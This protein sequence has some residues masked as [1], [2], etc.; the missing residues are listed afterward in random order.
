[1]DGS[2]R[3]GHSDRAL[4]Q[5]DRMSSARLHAPRRP[6]V[7]LVLTLIGMFFAIPAA[8]A[9][10]THGGDH[11]RVERFL[12]LSTDPTETDATVLGFGP[13]HAKGI[14]HVVSDTE[15]VFEFPDG[16]VS[17]THTPKKSNDSFDPATCLATFWERGSY[18]ITGG[19]GDYEG[20]SG[21]GHYR[22]S[23]LA[24]GCDENAPPDPFTLTIRA[25]GPLFL[26]Q[27]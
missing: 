19:T 27:S 21:H 8:V 20:A 18:Q 26:A 7:V 23:V 11:T 24:V 2:R 13:I 4:I 5:G 17:V 15:D 9:G 10:G 25:K 16:T 3:L 12:L 6:A 1:M 22:V 14:D